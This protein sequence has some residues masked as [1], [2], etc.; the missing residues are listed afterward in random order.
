MMDSI[1]LEHYKTVL[2]NLESEITEGL[3]RP[4]D[5]T[6]TVKLDTSIG[7]LSRIDAMQSQLMALELKRRQEQRLMR[8]QNALKAIRKGTYG[9][10]RRCHQPMDPARLEAQ[11]DAVLCLLCAEGV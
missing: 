7:R 8:V 3:E 6:A 1:K 10:C 11:P 5:A 9:E 4:S 2:L